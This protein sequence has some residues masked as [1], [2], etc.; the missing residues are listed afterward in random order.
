MYGKEYLEWREQERLRRFDQ[1]CEAVLSLD[2][3]NDSILIWGDGT[4]LTDVGLKKGQSP[5]DA[6]AEERGRNAQRRA[7]GLGLGDQTTCFKPP[8]CSYPPRGNFRE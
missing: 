8:P 5:A 7:V 1:A 6:R 2:G 3:D 4:Y